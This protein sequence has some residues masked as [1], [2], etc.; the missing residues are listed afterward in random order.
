MYLHL[1][2]PCV[3]FHKTDRLKF[4]SSEL[5]EFTPHTKAFSTSLLR[6]IIA[7]NRLPFSK[8]FS[9]FEIV[10]P[11]FKF[12]SF[13]VLFKHFAAFFALFLKNRTHVICNDEPNRAI[14]SINYSLFF[15]ILKL[16]GLY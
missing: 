10:A 2:S 1:C 8:I 15:Q 14:S 7:H 6:T 13:L 4:T 3:L 5:I 12:L 9:N 11:V 16:N